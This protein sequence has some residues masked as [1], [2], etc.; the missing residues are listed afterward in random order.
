MSPLVAAAQE[1]TDSAHGTKADCIGIEVQDVQ[2]SDMQRAVEEET[3]ARSKERQVCMLYTIVSAHA[4]SFGLITVLPLARL[5]RS[6]GLECNGI[7]V[8]VQID[9]CYIVLAALQC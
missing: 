3:A 8:N 6:I 1:D 5:W 2:L 9:G 7:S 4:I